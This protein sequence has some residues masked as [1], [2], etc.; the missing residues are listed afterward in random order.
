[1]SINIIKL[2]YTSMFPNVEQNNPSQSIGGYCAAI[3]GDQSSSLV[4]PESF[5][6]KELSIY[7]NNIEIDN[8]EK[9]AGYDYLGINSEVIKVKNID[10]NNVY[11]DKRHLNG[12]LNF[13]KENDQVR[14]LKLNQIFND[15]F[16]DNYKQYRC[17]AIKNISE[18]ETAFNV[19]IR[20]KNSYGAGIKIALE[21]PK[22]EFRS[23]T[24]GSGTNNVFFDSSVP[25]LPENY[26]KDALVTFKSGENSGQSRIINEYD[27]EF[28][29]FSLD[30]N[31][32]HSLQQGDLYFIDCGPAQRIYSGISEPVVGND[33]VSNFVNPSSSNPIFIDFNS[34]R[35]HGGDLR[36]KD[37]VFLWLERTLEKASRGRYESGITVSV[38]YYT[39]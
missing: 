34:R 1:M 25:A 35:R 24:V 4:F 8:Y 10:D 6:T 32:S 16:N 21:Y 22:S 15:V 9:L 20:L 12:I 29:S 19:S 27:P 26:F 36:P 38:D 23:G 5:I 31:L 11:V 17:I 2:Y 28:K 14:G 39:I 7:K 3:P 18:E 13:H 30:E 37:V 33:N